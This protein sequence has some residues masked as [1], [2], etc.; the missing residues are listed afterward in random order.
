MLSFPYLGLEADLVKW[1]IIYVELID[2]ILLVLIELDSFYF[3][4]VW[5]LFSNLVVDIWMEMLGYFEDIWTLLG[6]LDWYWR[7]ALYVDSDSGAIWV[8]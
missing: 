7:V 2:T 5:D 1:L 4:S 3:Y 6:L 8:S